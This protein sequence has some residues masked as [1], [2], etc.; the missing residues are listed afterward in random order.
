MDQA[1]LRSKI[2]E[3]QRD[4]NLTDEEKAKKR[5]EL[6]CAG[7]AKAN[8]TQAKE[9]QERK[10][11]GEGRNKQRRCEAPNRSERKIGMDVG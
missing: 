8:P 2:L 11:Q 6:M 7:F 9:V 4:A 10:D 1:E 5:Q 3:I